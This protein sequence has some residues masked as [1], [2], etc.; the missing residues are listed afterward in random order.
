M[1]KLN[2][3]KLSQIISEAQLLHR[4][5]KETLTQENVQAAKKKESEM[6]ETLSFFER[7][8]FQLYEQ[9]K[10]IPMR[11]RLYSKLLDEKN[12]NTIRS[13]GSDGNN[14]IIFQEWNKNTGQKLKERVM[15]KQVE[16]QGI[17]LSHDGKYIYTGQ[18]EGDDSSGRIKLINT[19]RVWDT[20]T[21]EC[22]QILKG[23]NYF[24]VSII[25]SVDG[26]T[27][28]SGSYDGT[29]K[30]WDK[31]SGTCMQTLHGHEG[32]IQS[33][34]EGKD[35]KTIISDADDGTIRFWDK[36]SGKE[37][38]KIYVD[39]KDTPEEERVGISKIIESSNGREM[40]AA[41]S[42]GRIRIID[43]Q[44]LMFREIPSTYEEDRNSK[45]INS[46]MK[47]LADIIE[48]K[49]GRTI[50]SMQGQQIFI[51]DKETLELLNTLSNDSGYISKISEL[52]DGKLLTAYYDGLGIWGIPKSP[53]S[54]KKLP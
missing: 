31:S 4:Q 17:C 41:L 11:Q 35:G 52:Q 14:R 24:V 22:K 46:R 25:E 27:L 30:I 40:I 37:I 18:E 34:L 5:L 12:E 39:E 49:N 10:I 47:E 36:S 1:N 45:F 33:V 26:Q 53:T 7:F 54:P 28:F 43:L 6:L 15:E 48:T 13:I 9:I 42:D 20:E 44:T 23:H 29:I 2:C 16:A 38:S 51:W 8:K 32:H 19:I 21:G 3:Q 50:I